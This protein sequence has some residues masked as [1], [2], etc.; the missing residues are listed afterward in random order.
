MK[1]HLFVV[2]ESKNYLNLLEDLHNESRRVVEELG[3]GFEWLQFAE[4]RI[5]GYSFL[6]KPD[7]HWAVLQK[8]A[9]RV[10]MKNPGFKFGFIVD[11][12]SHM[13]NTTI[14]DEILETGNYPIKKVNSLENFYLNNLLIQVKPTSIIPRHPWLMF[15]ETLKRKKLLYKNLTTGNS[16]KVVRSVTKEFVS[17]ELFS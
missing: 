10:Q 3:E 8:I 15:Q 5:F 13:V 6:E 9:F 17:F 2:K 12:L 16:Y 11:E 4:K 14:L 7:E 1:N